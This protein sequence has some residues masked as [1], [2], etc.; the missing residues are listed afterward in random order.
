MQ[1]T[2]IEEILK[3][4]TYSIDFGFVYAYESGD[5]DVARTA[6]WRDVIATKSGDEGFGPLVESIMEDGWDEESAVG[7][8]DCEIT[9]GHHR[10]VA[11]ILLGMDEVPTCSYGSGGSS[12]IMA[13]G[14][15]VN[16]YDIQVII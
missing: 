16:D 15:N 7:W 2:S 8:N 3:T 1:M 12:P 5:M 14:G 6:F 10:L 9:E 11:A 13:Y 4:V